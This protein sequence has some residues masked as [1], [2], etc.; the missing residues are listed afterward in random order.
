MKVI[1]RN[2]STEIVNLNKITER[3]RKLI[4]QQPRLSIDPIVVATRVIGGLYDGVTTRE[5]DILA[6]ETCASMAS[7]HPD[8][9]MLASRLV[10]SGLHKETLGAF[11]LVTEELEKIEILNKEYIN[12]V[13]SNRNLLDAISDYNRDYSFDYFGIQTLRRSY[14]LR[15]KSKEIIERPQDMWLR[16]ATFLHM[17][18]GEDSIEKIRETYNLLSQKYYTHATPT[19]FNAGTTKPQLSSCF[20]LDIDSDSVGGI[21]KTLS[22]CAKISQSAGGIGLAIHKIRSQGSYIHGTNGHS[23]GI[24]PML[25]VFDTTARYI[26]QGG[27]R[28][29]GSFAIYL[30]P[31]HADIFDFL[32]L[33][34]N[35]GKEELRA[36]D[37]FY[38]IWT[39][40]LFMQRVEEN[41]NWTLFDPA[42][43]YE[44][45]STGNRKYLYDTY[46]DD[47]KRIYEDLE[48]QG[49]GERI[50]KAQDLW[51]KIL[52]NQIETGTPYILYK[53]AANT[54]SNQKNLGTIKSSNLC[55]EIIEYTDKDEIAV[56]NLA[57]LSL[58]AYIKDGEF[59]FDKLYSVTRKVTE[60]LDKL[61]DI[62]YYPI[63]EGHT[64]NLR[65]RPI[66]IGVQGLADTFAILKL[67]FDGQRA[68]NINK[69]IFETIYKGAI[70]ESI[71]LARTKKQYETYSG[72]PASFGQL[73][74]D[75]WG[76]DKDSLQYDW[77]ETYTNLATYGLRN[78][79]LVAPMPTASTS[80]ILGN[81]EAFEPFTSNMYT[82]GTLAGT[83]TVVN[84]HLVRELLELNLW[85]ERLRQRLIEANGSI[86]TIKEIPEEIRERYRTVWEMKMK[87][88]I[89]MSADRAPFICQSQSLNLFVT[90]PTVSKLTSMHFYGWKKGLKTGMYYLRTQ[91]V[92]DAIK[93]TVNKE[94]IN[95]ENK[96]NESNREIR[97]ETVGQTCSLEDPSCE[98]CSG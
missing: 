66:G 54:K 74:F 46:G 34:K 93:F 19:L 80:Q 39:P 5:L 25:R 97:E 2:G 62:N 98:A 9:D 30:E 53:D 73:Q 18:G 55:T 75:L 78:S 40:D 79:L 48:S 1:K 29:K 38:G 82:R 87:D 28:R 58:P 94:L 14:L 90:D 85:D 69:R 8:Y 61:I 47:F 71:E 6:S 50:I 84:K 22:D 3:L 31:W 56:C 7:Q 27:G 52:E 81:N 65:H 68:K 26:D 70:D 91:A 83:F 63:P 35:H 72:S 67:T 21:Y 89:D 12:Y 76:L 36:R 10:V 24:I 49:K 13:K 45:D 43:A 20:L 41:G 60:N 95:E 51:F 37:L 86:Q 15:A 23:N 11:S 92:V 88:I 42:K 77:S 59:D 17:S 33:K 44:E 96:K 57:S 4:T 16:V 32:D 64:S